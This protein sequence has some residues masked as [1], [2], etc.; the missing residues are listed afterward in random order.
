MDRLESDEFNHDCGFLMTSRSRINFRPLLIWP[1]TSGIANLAEFKMHRT[2][3]AILHLTNMINMIIIRHY[4]GSAGD[5]VDGDSKNFINTWPIFAFA[6]GSCVLRPVIEGLFGIRPKTDEET[7][8]VDQHMPYHWPYMKIK[9]LRIRKC[10]LDLSSERGEDSKDTVSI[11]NKSKEQIEMKIGLNYPIGTKIKAVYNNT[12]IGNEKVDF[13][14]NKTNWDLH[15]YSQIKV[16]P[17][18][19]LKLTIIRKQIGPYIT[20]SKYYVLDKALNPKISDSLFLKTQPIYIK[21]KKTIIDAY[22]FGGTKHKIRMKYFDEPRKVLID[23]KTTHFKYDK[24]KKLLEFSFII[25]KGIKLNFSEYKTS[26]DILINDKSWKFKTD[27]NCLGIKENWL[28]TN[29]D[30]SKWSQQFNTKYKGI[31]WFRTKFNV[32]RALKRK[33]AIMFFG[34]HGRNFEIYVNGKL[35]YDSSFKKIR[36][37][38]LTK[39]FQKDE[40]IFAIRF[41]QSERPF[42]G[43][44]R[45][46]FLVEAFNEEKGWKTLELKRDSSKGIFDWYRTK[47][48]LP[49]KFENTILRLKFYPDEDSN[50]GVTGK[51]WIFVNG[52]LINTFGLAKKKIRNVY[53]HN[54]IKCGKENVIVIG[55][56]EGNLGNTKI[57]PVKQLKIEIH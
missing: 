46:N 43:I 7:I 25:D 54:Y 30:D 9:N 40:I 14:I 27:P 32:P 53:I 50:F 49:R 22:A 15:V 45:I 21:N 57:I 6:I 10:I 18:S 51:C 37:I 4:P 12:N 52:K 38:E 11:C 56:R 23:G 33:R 47:F 48:Y 36:S 17:F 35:Y 26:P 2:E 19:K 44:P 20:D 16:K 34:G 55:T 39:E 3:Q 8:I 13:V 28:G 42:G 41:D 5:T 31:S 1:W 24:D 29:Y